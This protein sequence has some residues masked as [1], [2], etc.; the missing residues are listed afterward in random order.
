MD[1]T[2][3]KTTLKWWPSPQEYNEAIQHTYDCFKNAELQT[4]VVSLDAFGLPKPITGGFASVY[5][6]R[7]Q[8][9]DYAVRCFLRNLP[10]TVSRYREVAEFLRGKQIKPFVGFELLQDGI[11]VN[12]QWFPILKM[13]WVEGETLDS[14][15]KTNRFA[16]GE[17]AEKFK[18]MCESLQKNG[19]AH[20]DL[21]HGNIMVRND[22]L[23]LVDYDGMYVPSLAGKGSTEAGH[24]NYQ[25][26]GRI[27]KHFGPYL[28]NFSAWVI[29][30][31]LKAIALD[32]TLYTNL[33]AGDDCLLFRSEDF[34]APTKSCAFVALEGHH[35]Q[36]L[37]TIAKFLRSQLK[38][39]PEMVPPLGAMPSSIPDLEPLDPYTV[40]MRLFT[41]AT[42]SSLPD[43]LNSA[44][45]NS[46]YPSEPSA[47][48][49]TEE[50][51]YYARHSSLGTQALAS[52]P[53][54]F[55]LPPPKSKWLHSAR[56]LAS[57]LGVLMLACFAVR[58]HIHHA[59]DYDAVKAQ[60][61]ETATTP[62]STTTSS[63]QT[64]PIIGSDLW[65]NKQGLA[66]YELGELDK[67]IENFTKA[68]EI[69]PNNVQAY[70]YRARA[71]NN[72]AKFEMAIADADKAITIDPNYSNAY[73]RRAYA[74]TNLEQ[75]E[76]AVADC[77]KAIS[78][79]PK[80]ADAYA[81]RAIAYMHE[82]KPELAIEDSSQAMRLDP[83]GHKPYINRAGAYNNL[84]RFDEALADLTT[85]I[86]L[87]P[88]DEAAFITRA[89]TE[90]QLKKYNEAID[91]CT[92]ALS[93][94][95]VPSSAAVA[96]GNR[97]VA[98]MDLGKNDQAMQDFTAAIRVLPTYRPAYENRADLYD[99]LGQTSLAAADRAAAEKLPEHSTY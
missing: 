19:I 46:T 17:L 11:R 35:N 14:Y 86:K 64:S 27:E 82:E 57:G 39:S 1:L 44:S 10:E 61:V 55:K 5:R 49:L 13:D 91:D 75:P 95:L 63:P 45:T 40:P 41:A 96:Y 36:E 60:G 32:P 77:T 73:V 99:K 72:T 53:L 62:A 59:P 33:G 81:N 71:Y 37:G 22:E 18:V 26:P 79:D 30:L 70:N 88:R 98:Y 51:N 76:K 92:H 47:A 25:H 78:I 54:Q 69:N 52:R 42:A 15:L 4:G 67:A 90:I 93:F 87:D 56:L 28:D 24:R 12:G 23:V 34:L 85:A 6:V 65:Y 16:L 89:S 50:T 97:G 43:W 68:I 3:Q 21:Q 2:Q 9:A 8:P 38:V 83:T 80:N 20:G 94:S 48:P 58:L 29:Y 74:Y 66:Y 31:S 7:V 84:G